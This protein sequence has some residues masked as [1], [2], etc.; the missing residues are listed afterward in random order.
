LDHYGELGQFSRPGSPRLTRGGSSPMLEP[1][2][3]ILAYWGVP[4]GDTPFPLA[5][6]SECGG[7]VCRCLAVK[8]AQPALDESA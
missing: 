5:A 8:E 3:D 7:V 6:C 2:P 1:I 4:D